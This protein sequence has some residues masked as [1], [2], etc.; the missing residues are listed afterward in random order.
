MKA[1]LLGS[2]KPRFNFPEHEIIVPHHSGKNFFLKRS[3]D[4]KIN[5]SLY[6]SIFEACSGQEIYQWLFKDLF[7]A[8]YTH[9]DAKNFVSW[10]NLGWHNGS[11][12]VFFVV[13]DIGEVVAA[14]DIKNADLALAEVGYWVASSYAGLGS[15]SFALLILIARNVGF[16]QLFAQTKKGNLRSE[17]LLKSNGFEEN[18]ALLKSPTCQ[19]AYSL[20][21]S[22]S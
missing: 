14:L 17:K 9:D 5:E 6:H 22:N 4:V 13:N 16:K 1:L 11:H 2:M 15:N 3:I 10:A 21:L 8:G 18:P 19:K 20:I 12:F 7:P